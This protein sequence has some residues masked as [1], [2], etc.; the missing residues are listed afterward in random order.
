MISVSSW[1]SVSYELSLFFFSFL[2]ERGM[3]N[4][5]IITEQSMTKFIIET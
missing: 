1:L 2:I 5:A 4:K 3:T